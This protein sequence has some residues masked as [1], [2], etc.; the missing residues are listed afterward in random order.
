MVIYTM[1]YG[2]MIVDVDKVHLN[3]QM[4]ITTLEIGL[5]IKNKDS[6]Y[7]AEQMETNMKVIG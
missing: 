2:K 5:I 6:D 1:D 4:V 7:I 3:G